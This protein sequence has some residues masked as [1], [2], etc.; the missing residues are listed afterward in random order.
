MNRVK[1]IVLMIFLFFILSIN[2][3]GGGGAKN[4]NEVRSTTLGQELLDLDAAY[5]KGVISE[6][7]Y[8]DSKKRIMERYK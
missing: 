6:K 8:K 7:E 4:V 2:G 3:C 5:N 1:W